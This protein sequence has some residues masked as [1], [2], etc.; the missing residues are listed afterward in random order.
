MTRLLTIL[1]LLTSLQ[2]DKPISRP[3]TIKRT[4]QVVLLSEALKAKGLP[5]DPEPIALQ[6]VLVESDGTITPMLSDDAS[7]ALFKDERLRGRKA[8][9]IARKLPGLP[10]LQVVS[11]KVEDAGVLRI[12]EYY[13]DVC[14]ISVRSPQTCP[15]CQGP[16]DLR[17]KPENR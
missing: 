4:G 12:P 15:C 9:L 10:F 11:F 8:E 14:S 2:A 1:L 13:C 3:E 6:V 17:M 16:M 5:A 7:R